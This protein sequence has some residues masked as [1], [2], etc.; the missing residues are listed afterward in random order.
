MVGELDVEAAHDE[1]DD[2]LAE[3]TEDLGERAN[4]E[5]VCTGKRIVKADHGVLGTHVVND[6]GTDERS[7]HVEQATGPSVMPSRYSKNR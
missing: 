5:Q 3:E 1:A 7:G 6:E 4:G 2:C